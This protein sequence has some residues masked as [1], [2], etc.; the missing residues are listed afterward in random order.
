MITGV[1]LQEILHDVIDSLSASGGAVAPGTDPTSSITDYGLTGA[2]DGTN[3]LF[4]TSRSFIALT[5]R[6]YLNG[7]RQFPGEDYTEQGDNEILFLNAPFTNDKIIVDY[8]Y[9]TS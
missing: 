4:A 2:V 5:P 1:D 3:Q 6:V 9:L 8:I 7:V